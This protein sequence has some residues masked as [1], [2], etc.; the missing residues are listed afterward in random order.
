MSRPWPIIAVEDVRK[1]SAWYVRLLGARENHPGAT[2]FNQI[3]DEDGT[4]LVCPHCWGP[5]GP[6]GDHE[7]PPLMSPS[8]G[9]VGNGLLL[10]FVVNDFDAAWERARSLSPNVHESPNTNN[11][12][13]MRAFVVRDPD[14]YYVTVNE[15]RVYADPSATSLPR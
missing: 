10:W 1:S 15:A 5:S 6:R 14:G 12:T 2:V 9:R 11:G 7:W 4:V 8:A 3:L 13:G